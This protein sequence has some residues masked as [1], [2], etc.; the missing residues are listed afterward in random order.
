MQTTEFVV[1][2][3]GPAG[4]CAAQ[5][6]ARAG[7]DVLVLE[8]HAEVGPKVCAGGLTVKAVQIL[9]E[10]GLP[11]ELGRTHVAQASFLGEEPWPFDRELAVVRTIS[12]RALGQ[13]QAR[14]TCQA[15]ATIRTNASVTTV[16]LAERR[17][18]INR[19]ESLRYE[20]LIGADGSQ[21]VVRQALGLP[22]PR[23]IFAAEYNI[24]AL[25]MDSLRVSLGTARMKES[26]F[27]IFPHE[28]YT[29]IGYGANR[30]QV[31]P[32]EV[33]RHLDERLRSAGLSPAGAPLEGYSIECKYAGIDFGR[34]HLVGDA[35]GLASPL[36]GEG[37]RAALV[38]GQEVALSL[39]DSG[40]TRPQLRQWLR[41]HAL[42]T[43]LAGLPLWR[44][45][46]SWLLT[47]QSTRALCRFAAANRAMIALC[48]G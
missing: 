38:S 5:T 37:I 23:R 44:H 15:G 19:R 32:R 35:A 34:V 8:R 40:H 46:I 6:L 43:R 27:W 42:H 2:G 11:P 36:T 18:T 21:S 13:W 12:R 24:P 14:L 48:V 41:T 10:M 45:D 7:R 22:C 26:Y 9:A 39:L 29:S 1:V 4:L 30:M 31:P 3:A 17:L 20:H 33:C 47:L 16:D 28:G 25:E